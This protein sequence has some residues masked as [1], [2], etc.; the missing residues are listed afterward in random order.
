MTPTQQLAEIKLG[1][2]LEQWVNEARDRGDSWR[3]ISRDLHLATGVTVS[4][5]S[6]RQW[7]TPEVAS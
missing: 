4:D 1:H 6:L 2:P 5:E 3:T 7:F